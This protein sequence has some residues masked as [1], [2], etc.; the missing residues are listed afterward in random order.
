M[1]SDSGTLV[2]SRIRWRFL[3]VV[4]KLCN[5]VELIPRHRHRKIAAPFD[6]FDEAAGKI[7]LEPAGQLLQGHRSRPTL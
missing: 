4:K 6:G 3:I 2:L 5:L 7:F 1:Q